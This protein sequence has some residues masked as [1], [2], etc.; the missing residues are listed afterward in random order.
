M[1]QALGTSTGLFRFEQGGQVQDGGDV[2]YLERGDGKQGTR[3]RGRGGRSY[4]GKRDP[5]FPVKL[6]G[7]GEVHAAF[8][9]ESCAR[10]RIQ[11]SV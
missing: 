4:G 9:N 5:G 8:L 3:G 2:F 10:G 11:Q 6:L 1:G 7:F